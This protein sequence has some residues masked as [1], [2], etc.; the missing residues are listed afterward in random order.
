MI[1]PHPALKVGTWGRDWFPFDV[2]GEVVARNNKR[3]KEDS[4]KARYNDEQLCL[5]HFNPPGGG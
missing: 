2:A 1:L 4:K 3:K 5:F